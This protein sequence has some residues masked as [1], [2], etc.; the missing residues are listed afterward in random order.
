MSLMMWQ[1]CFH[2][3]AA[4]RGRK[5]R[6]RPAHRAR[7]AMPLLSKTSVTGRGCVREAEA[8]AAR[9]C[10]RP[11]NSAAGALWSMPWTGAPV[12]VEPV[13]AP[14][15]A[16]RLKA[17]LPSAPPSEATRTRPLPEG[18]AAS[19]ART[20][21]PGGLSWRRGGGA[22]GS[23]KRGTSNRVSDSEVGWRSRVGAKSGQVQVRC[24]LEGLGSPQVHGTTRFSWRAAAFP[25]RP[26]AAATRRRGGVASHKACSVVHG[27]DAGGNCCPR[28]RGSELYRLRCQ[29]AAHACSMHAG[30]SYP[31]S[32]T[33]GRQED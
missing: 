28:K 33:P 22:G 11:A 4:C 29:D 12:E 31:R 27:Q 18:E 21:W 3:T 30:P 24:C 8:T 23:G 2:A 14:H 5:L 26:A 20:N 10:K 1:I 19:M 6:P 13:A 25:S 15:A 32:S 7:S 9:T 16:R 17:S